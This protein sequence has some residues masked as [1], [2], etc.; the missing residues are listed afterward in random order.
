MDPNAEAPRIHHPR[1][2]PP[3][4]FAGPTL[5]NIT[6]DAWPSASRQRLFQDATPPRISPPSRA[7]PRTPAE[8]SFNVFQELQQSRQHLQRACELLAQTQVAGAD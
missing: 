4:T 7:T 5:D 3:P 8:V 2:Q 1:I 6:L